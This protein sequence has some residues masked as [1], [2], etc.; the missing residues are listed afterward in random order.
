MDLNMGRERRYPTHTLEY[1]D[2]K[3]CRGLLGT[4]TPRTRWN[5]VLGK[6][7]AIYFLYV[8][9]FMGVRD[10]N[11]AQCLCKI[12]HSGV[13]LQ[14]SLWL[15]VLSE[16][17]EIMKFGVVFHFATPTHYKGSTYF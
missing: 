5:I 4:D 12:G 15:L 1:R 10:H 13:L 6:I 17:Q 16:S 3:I 11:T 9:S 8:R 2:L 14:E 7:G